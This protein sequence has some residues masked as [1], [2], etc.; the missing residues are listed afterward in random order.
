MELVKI[1]F[2]NI[3]NVL[4]IDSHIKLINNCGAYPTAKYL[5]NEGFSLDYAL[6]CLSQSKYANNLHKS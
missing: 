6:A 4:L 2:K 5:K 1:D 3:K